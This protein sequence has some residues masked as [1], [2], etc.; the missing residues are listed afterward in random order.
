[1]N[2]D[3][4]HV[5]QALWSRKDILTLRGGP[6]VCAVS[7]LVNSKGSIQ[8]FTIQNSSKV[9]FMPKIGP[10]GLFVGPKS[11]F[12]TMWA[13]FRPPW[14]NIWD[15]LG[16][17]IR[18]NW[19]AIMS[20]M[21]FQPCSNPFDKKY[22]I[23][24]YFIIFGPPLASFLLLLESNSQVWH[25]FHL[26]KK[27]QT[28]SGPMPNLVPPLPTQNMPLLWA[29]LLGQMVF[30]KI[31]FGPLYG[32]LGPYLRHSWSGKWAN[33]FSLDVFSAVSIMFQ[34]VPQ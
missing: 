21:L 13:P 33:L 7:T 3:E 4:Q 31:L 11:Y 9:L 28:L 19:S 20:S 14:G 24:P 12:Q 29:D 5:L 25:P 34:P 26:E 16:L 30:F 23:K 15:I 18:P 17:A 10:L 22:E 2:G 8:K 1:M 32:P 27:N 6:W